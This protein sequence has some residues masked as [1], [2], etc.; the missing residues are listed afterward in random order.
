MSRITFLDNANQ[1]KNNWWRYLLTIFLVAMGIIGGSIGL[2]LII[3]IF[4]IV[5]LSMTGLTDPGQLMSALYSL[6]SEPFFLLIGGGISYIFALVMLFIGIRFIHNRKFI[7]LVNTDSKFDFKRVLKGAGAWSVIMLVSL[8]ATLIIDPSGI[9]FTFNPLGFVI[10]LILSLFIF[11]IQASTEELFF[12]GYLMQGFALL[13]KKPIIPLILTSI[14]FSI[15]HYWNGNTSLEGI[16]LL[17][18]TFVMGITLGIIVLGENRLETAMG[19]HIAN[20]IFVTVIFNDP[21]SLFGE[22]PSIISYSPTPNPLIDV[23]FI[24][25]WSLILLTIIFWNKKENISNIFRNN[26]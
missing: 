25:L 9:K 15:G 21:N 7:T 12:R 17:L 3:G 1:G 16:D 14:I 6:N 18:Q 11:A 8:A 26:S 23:P 2:G 13:T 22:L 5:Y 4:Y 20:N 10:L 24:V 19:V